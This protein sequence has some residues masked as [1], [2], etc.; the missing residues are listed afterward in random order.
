MSLPKIKYPIFD[1][2]LPSTKEQINFRPFTVKEEKLLLIAQESENQADKIRAIRQIINNCCFNLPKDVGLL[3]SFDLEYCFMKIRA[4]SIG[5]IVELKYKDLTDKKIYTFEVDLDELEIKFNP[6]HNKTVSI[7]DDLGLIMKYPTIEV[8]ESVK[9]DLKSTESSF[10]I[11]KKCI[12]T[13]YDSDN[14]YDTS[15]YSDEDLSVFV[16]SIP[17]KAF[18]GITKFFDTSPT[19]KHELKYKD[20]EGTEKTI[21][22]QGIDDFFQ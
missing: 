17:A 3:P 11:I 18:E 15:D 21:T 2:T 6:E 19:L 14:T 9:D 10:T 12:E 5:N 7:S 4:K 1:L 20:E 8:L 22:L 13:I 16:E